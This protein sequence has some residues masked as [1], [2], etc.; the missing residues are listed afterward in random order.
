MFYSEFSSLG[1]VAIEIQPSTIRYTKSKEK[2][3]Q[4]RRTFDDRNLK[5]EKDLST[6]R[7][8]MYLAVQF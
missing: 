4:S 3:A 5:V 1:D 6:T 2:Q 7:E 8:Q